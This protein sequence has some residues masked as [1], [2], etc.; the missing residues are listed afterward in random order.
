MRELSDVDLY[1][2]VLLDRVIYVLLI[3]C[4]VLP[5][6]CTYPIQIVQTMQVEEIKIYNTTTQLAFFFLQKYLQ[7]FYRSTVQNKQC[8]KDYQ[9]LIEHMNPNSITM[10]TTKLFETHYI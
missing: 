9:R 5:C 1:F 10:S 2:T 7:K 4:H 8:M 6:V 3:F